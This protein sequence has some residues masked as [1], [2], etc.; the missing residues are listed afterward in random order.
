MATV[1]LRISSLPNEAASSRKTLAFATV[2][3]GA[4]AL[5]SQLEPS[6]PLNDH[7]VWIWGMVQGERRYLKSLQSEGAVM[8]IQASGVSEPIELKPNGAE[9]L[10]LLG[11]N[12][13]I[14]RGK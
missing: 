14:G 12:L 11:A 5:K 4:I 8:T 1:T 13:V 10:H 9:M 6:A 2:K 7:L 3:D